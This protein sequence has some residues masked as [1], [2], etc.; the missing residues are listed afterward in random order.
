MFAYYGRSL[1]DGREGSVD[2]G[3]SV[4]PTP[5]AFVDSMTVTNVDPANA[6][7]RVDLETAAAWLVVPCCCCCCLVLPTRHGLVEHVA[8]PAVSP[9]GD[10][11]TFS[12]IPEAIADVG[13]CDEVEA[14][15]EVAVT[16][17][18]DDIII[19]RGASTVVAGTVATDTVV[20]ETVCSV[21]GGCIVGLVRLV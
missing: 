13:I 1:P 18:V 5:A 21:V 16:L 17:L 6:K 9:C 11:A 7:E 2:I 12:V 3:H 19:A 14:G 4:N 15:A 10:V 20:I 8:S